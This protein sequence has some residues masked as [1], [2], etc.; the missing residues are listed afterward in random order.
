[1]VASVAKDMRILGT[2]LY[3][4]FPPDGVVG[5]LW[6][7]MGS[8]MSLGALMEPFVSAPWT[9]ST[10]FGGPGALEPT[11]STVDRLLEWLLS[12]ASSTLLEDSMEPQ[13]TS[14]NY[15]LHKHRVQQNYLYI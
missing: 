8:S 14:F 15:I 10:L 11:W 4:I 2:V 6:Y 12:M 13:V 3:Q 7:L 9:Y 1:M 5:V